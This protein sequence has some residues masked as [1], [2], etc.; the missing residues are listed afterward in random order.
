[1]TTKQVYAHF[2]HLIVTMQQFVPDVSNEL[3]SIE[4][5]KRTLVL[6]A[7]VRPVL[8]SCSSVICFIKSQILTIQKMK[9]DFKFM[10]PFLLSIGD[11]S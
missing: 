6:E 11:A 9:L 8:A 3:L 7:L 10:D 2:W 1:M 4:E 5:K